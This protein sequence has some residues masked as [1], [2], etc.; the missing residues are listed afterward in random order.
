MVV[1]CKLV[2]QGIR[3]GF[4]AVDALLDDGQVVGMG[5][6]T[7]R[8]QGAWPFEVPGLDFE[9]VETALALAID[10]FPDR[11]ALKGRRDLLWPVASIGV[12]AAVD[13]EVVFDHDIGDLR[14]HDELD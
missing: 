7:R 6:N 4:V 3:N 14:Q 8:L 1:E 2:V 9:H 12:D 11:I 5:R 10:P 13:G